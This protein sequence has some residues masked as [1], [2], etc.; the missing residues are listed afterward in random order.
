MKSTLT[1]PLNYF[2]LNN[3]TLGLME[4]NPLWY[5]WLGWFW[6]EQKEKKCKI[7]EKIGGWG[8]GG[9]GFGCKGTEERKMMEPGY[10]LFG[11]TKIWLFQIREKTEVKMRRFVF[12]K[13][14]LP[15]Q[16]AFFFFSF[17]LL[18]HCSTDFGFLF[19]LFI[20][21]FF[22]FFLHSSHFLFFSF[23]CFYLCFFHS[24]SFFHRFWILPA[25]AIYIEWSVYNK[26][27]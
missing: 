20:T 1:R 24:R 21:F 27:F 7:G 15:H 4:N 18:F 16:Q 2:L 9:T 22:F 13:I 19:L 6:G 25:F 11:P 26:N 14:F 12:D 3:Y 5:V 17:F 10:F 23:F 8:G